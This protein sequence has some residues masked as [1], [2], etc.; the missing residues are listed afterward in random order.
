MSWLKGQYALLGGF[1]K[2]SFK[3]TVLASALAMFTGVVLGCIITLASPGVVK[4]FLN[5]FMEGVES[6]GVVDEAGEFSFFALLTHNWIAMLASAAYGFMPFLFLP[7]LAAAMNGA[8]LGMMGVWYAVAGLPMSAYF[9]GILPHGVFELTAL[10]LSA[11]CGVALCVNLCRMV[12]GSP[13]RV[14]MVELLSDL[15]RVLLLLVMP[16]TVCAAAMEC[17]VTPVVMS[18]FL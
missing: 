11:A 15:L 10:V 4:E 17:Y 6:A 16:L 1:C 3:R 18:W 9:A 2:G 13:R 12:V 14:P 5:Y 8:M 7:A